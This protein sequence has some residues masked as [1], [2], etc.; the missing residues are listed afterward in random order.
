[1]DVA[2]GHDACGWYF[3]Y[4]LAFGALAFHGMFGLFYGMALFQTR[5]IEC[6]FVLGRVC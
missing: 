3:A 5:S 6:C 1:M 2:L 4:A